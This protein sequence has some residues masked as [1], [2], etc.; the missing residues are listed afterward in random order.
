MLHKKKTKP[1]IDLIA[2]DNLHVSRNE[3]EMRDVTG[4]LR[5]PERRLGDSRRSSVILSRLL[6]LTFLIGPLRNTVLYWNSSGHSENTALTLDVKLKAHS[7]YFFFLP[8]GVFF[9]ELSSLFFYTFTFSLNK[10][11]LEEKDKE[12]E[13]F[14]GTGVSKKWTRS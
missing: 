12:E 2:R 8:A 11:A 7:C 10:D 13:W 4:R 14:Q 6:R 5:S 3:V 1:K 9:W